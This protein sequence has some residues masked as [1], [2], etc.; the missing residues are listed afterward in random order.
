MASCAHALALA[1]ED[2]DAIGNWVDRASTSP[3]QQARAES[4]AVKYS[5]ARLECCASQL[6]LFKGDVTVHH[7]CT[8]SPKAFA[9]FL[10]F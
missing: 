6:S 7:P 4:M 8:A 3:G 1:E 2:Q 10:S 5:D 9:F